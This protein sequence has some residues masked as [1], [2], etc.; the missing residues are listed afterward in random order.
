MEW[1][2]NV[3]GKVIGFVQV[4]KTPIFKG[5]VIVLLGAAGA[6]LL[7]QLAADEDEADAAMNDLHSDAEQN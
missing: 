4:H 3:V 5:G 7:G 1:L 6:L 2:A